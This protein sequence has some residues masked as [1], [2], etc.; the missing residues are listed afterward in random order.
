MHSRAGVGQSVSHGTSQSARG[1]G[2][3][4]AEQAEQSA[5]E[6]Y[7]QAFEQALERLSQTVCQAAGREGSWLARVRAGLVALLGFFDDEPLWGR[8]LVCDAPA[9]DVMLAL[10]C[11]QRVLGVLSGLLDDGAPRAIGEADV[12]A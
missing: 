3:H 2:L 6:R 9:T 12:R 4:G 10:R 7:L 5:G 1:E 8:L 11:E